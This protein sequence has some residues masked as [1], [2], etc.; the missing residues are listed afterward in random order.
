MLPIPIL[1]VSVIEGFFP[2]WLHGN[3][4]HILNNIALWSVHIVNNVFPASSFGCNIF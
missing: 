3:L 2:L 4:L 1:R